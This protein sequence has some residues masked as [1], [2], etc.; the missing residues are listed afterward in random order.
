MFLFV[1]RQISQCHILAQTALRKILFMM[2]SILTVMIKGVL[3]LLKA[4]A[5][6]VGFIIRVQH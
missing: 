5:F 2:H 6:I 4:L 3:F 1:G